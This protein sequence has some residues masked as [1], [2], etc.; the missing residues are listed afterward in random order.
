MRTYLAFCLPLLVLAACNSTPSSPEGKA[1]LS[2][3]VNEALAEFRR[4]DPGLDRFFQDSYGYAVFPNVGK[5]GMG[6]GGAY[7]R[8]EVYQGGRMIGR[9]DLSQATIG[10]QFG[11]QSYRELIFFR[12]KETFEQFKRGTFEVSAQASAVAVQ[13]GASETADYQNG[14]AIFTMTRGGLMYE[15]SIG[16]QRFRFV[17]AE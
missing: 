2:A 14:V 13:A 9:C 1:A 16:G 11:G 8:G 12:T 17:P 10:F 4:E 5:G 7:G 6:V 15:A 3:Q